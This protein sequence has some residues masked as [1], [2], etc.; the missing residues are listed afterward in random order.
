MADPRFFSVAGPFRLGEIAERTGACLLD[1]KHANR[2]MTDVAP[3]QEAT[4]DKL[5]FLDN[6]KYVSYFRETKAGACFVRD[7]VVAHAPAGVVCLVHKNPY[8][9]YAIAAQAFYPEPLVNEYRAPS[10]V[11]DPSATIGENVSIAHGAV[12]GKGV[13]IGQR[14]QIHPH[15]VIC[16][17]VEIGDDCEIGA[18]SYLTHCLL[19][20][21]VRLHPGVCIGRPGFGFA[22]DPAGY[23]RVPQLGRVIIESDVEIGANTT[24]DRGAGPDTV[25]GRGTR[26]DNLVQIGHNV[27][28]GKGCVVVAQ[29]GIS[30]STQLG[31]FVMT[32]GQ[33]GFAGHLKI[34]AGAKIAAQSGVMRDIPSAEEVMGTP[35]VPMKQYMR[36]VTIMSKMAHRKG[37]NE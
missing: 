21:Q 27:R 20:D 31:D 10:S 29:T 34:A 36:Q 19:G 3:L 37:G 9:A 32:G 12:I 35:A 11:I 30:G 26:I 13:R 6:K 23:I 8:K 25:I 5:S 1:E 4:E 16:D 14:C 28:L 7:D 18:N 2:V 15:A 24:I 17:N 22:I 33:S